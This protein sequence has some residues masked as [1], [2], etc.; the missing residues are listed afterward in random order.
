[1]ASF[2]D[3]IDDSSEKYNIKLESD[4]YTNGYVMGIIP[5]GNRFLFSL[6]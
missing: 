6:E 3:L 4:C 2:N 1:M 5:V